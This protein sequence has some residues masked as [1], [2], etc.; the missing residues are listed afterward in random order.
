M[1]KFIYDMINM[2]EGQKFIKYWWIWVIAIVVITGIHLVLDFQINKTL[3][4]LFRSD[5]K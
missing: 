4:K 5:K 3:E 1:R 2:T